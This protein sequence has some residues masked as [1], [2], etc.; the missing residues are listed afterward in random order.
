M[1]RG[2]VGYV[3]GD[4]RAEDFA[5]ATVS[6]GVYRPTR[7]AEVLLAPA[8]AAEF[9][10]SQLPNGWSLRNWGGVGQPAGSTSDADEDGLVLDGALAAHGEPVRGGRSLEFSGCFSARPDQHVGFGVDYVHPPWAMF[11]TKWGRRL[12]AR[13]N[14]TLSEDKM[15]AGDWLGDF[16][17]YRIDWRPLDLVYS[18]DGAKVAQLLVPMPAY[19]RPL[20]GNRRSGGSP[21][22][23]EWMRMSPYQRVGRLTSRVLDAGRRVQWK[24]VHWDSDTPPGTT[25]AVAVRTADEVDGGQR[26]SPW[27]MVAAPGPLGS[28]AGDSRA[29]LLQYQVDLATQDPSTTPVLRRVE[30]RYSRPGC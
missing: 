5:A 6:P 9:G 15:L 27:T 19:M 28:P 22:T 10:G 26:W 17:R 12:Y 8:M 20:A 24:E 13:T 1:E 4:R 11:S 2:G 16:H 23:L 30:A 3:V 21:L 29:R 25:L 7:S 18:I 14:F